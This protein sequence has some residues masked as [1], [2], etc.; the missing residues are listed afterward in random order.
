M[1]NDNEPLKVGD[2]CVIVSSFCSCAGCRTQ[3]GW[4]C[5]VVADAAPRVARIGGGLLVPGNFYVV[6]VQDKGETKYAY[7]RHQLRKKRPPAD[8]SQR[9]R[10]QTMPREKFDQWLDG[11]RRGAKE[12]T[13]A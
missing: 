6:H 7:E 8:D 5:T 9:I 10:Q 3:I 1:F 12:E 2:V 13:P 4:E 11:V